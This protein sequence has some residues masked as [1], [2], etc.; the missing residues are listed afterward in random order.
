MFHFLL[1]NGDPFLDSTLLGDD[2]VVWKV[3]PSLVQH[4]PSGTASFSQFASPSFYSPSRKPPKHNSFF[5]AWHRTLQTEGDSGDCLFIVH[6][7]FYIKIAFSIFLC[8]A[9]QSHF[10][11][12]LEI[13]WME[14]WINKWSSR[15]SYQFVALAY[16]P[17][18]PNIEKIYLSKYHQTNK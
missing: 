14:K 10:W 9:A 18:L 12:S 3:N 5:R 4:L 6:S 16:L 17:I 7:N 2:S 11:G 8:E 1:N 13:G 15:K